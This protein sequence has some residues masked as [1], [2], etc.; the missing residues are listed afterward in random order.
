[1]AVMNTTPSTTNNDSGSIQR[2]HPQ[3]M[4]YKFLIHV[5]CHTLPDNSS[6]REC[7]RF[8]YAYIANCHAGGIYFD[9]QSTELAIL[10]NIS[11]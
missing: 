7:F 2:S 3:G 9:A 6:Q 5:E 1:M 4:T 10:N 8:A 11:P